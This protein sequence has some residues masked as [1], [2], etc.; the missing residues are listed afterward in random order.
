M[1]ELGVHVLQ[2]TP[3]RLDNIILSFLPKV[4]LACDVMGILNQTYLFKCIKIVNQT[5]KHN[6]IILPL[7]HFVNTGQK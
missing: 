2:V 3:Q 6:I 4:S 1:S 5:F 7:P